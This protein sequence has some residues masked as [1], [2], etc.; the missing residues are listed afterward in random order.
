MV[1]AAGRT[2]QRLCASRATKDPSR[3]FIAFVANPKSLVPLR[4][5]M[6]ESWA[7][8]VLAISSQAAYLWC[9]A[10]ALDSKLSQ[11]FARRAGE[12]VTMRNWATV[13]K[14]LAASNAAA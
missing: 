7:P 3:H 6:A 12:T 10:G 2:R 4:G 14:L 5:L 8:D 13:L 9:V 11:M 1:V